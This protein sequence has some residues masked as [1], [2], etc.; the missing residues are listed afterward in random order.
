MPTTL[1]SLRINDD[2]LEYLKQRAK[3][4]HRTLSNMICSILIEEKERKE[5][6]INSGGKNNEALSISCNEKRKCSGN[7]E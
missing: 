7:F 5:D 3:Q 6:K 4:E 1:V 2:L